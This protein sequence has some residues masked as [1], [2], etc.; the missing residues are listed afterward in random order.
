MIRDRGFLQRC[1]LYFSRR[2]KFPV[3]F[4]VDPTGVTAV[5]HKVGGRELHIMSATTPIAFIEEL[6]TL[7]KTKTKDHHREQLQNNDSQGS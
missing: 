5:Q 1:E 4:V 2:A 7:L 3:S 6:D